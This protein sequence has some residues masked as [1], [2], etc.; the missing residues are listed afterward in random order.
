ME[1]HSCRMK[2][3]VNT[4][5]AWRAS[6]SGE[7]DPADGS[8]GAG[9]LL[10]PES[11]GIAPLTPNLSL[12]PSSRNAPRGHPFLVVVAIDLGT[13]ASGYAYS[14]VQEP[15]TI[16][17]MR[18][19][20]GGDPG[21]ANQKIP[22]C[23][24]LTPGRSFHS[25]GYTARDFYHDLDPEEAPH[26]FYFDKFKMKIHSFNV[27]FAL[28]DLTLETELEAVNGKSMRALHVFAH[29][30]R[31]FQNQ[32]LKEL[33]E[34]FC[35]DLEEE[36][37]RWVI[38]VPAIW[39]QP[40]KQFMREAAYLAGLAS[41]DHAEQLLIALEPEAA[42]IYCRKLRLH[43]L[44]VLGSTETPTSQASDPRINSSFR[45]A[46]EQ[47]RRSRQSRTFLMENGVGDLWAEMES[48]DRYIV[49]D[50]G[51]GTVDLTV[52]EIEQPEGTLKELY[53][54]SGGPYGAV[55]VD[56]AFEELL[57]QIFGHDFIRCFKVKRP[58]AWV[59]LMIAFEARK[60][61]VS[62]KRTNPLNISLPFSFIDFYRK[63][64]GK[65]VEAAL[66]K[67][68]NN[69][70][71]W[72]SQGM[73]R[74]LP[75][76]VDELFQPTI[77][78]VVQHIDALLHRPEVAGVRFLFL[79]GGFAESP[80]LQRAVQQ[81]VGG[82][83]RLVLPHGLGLSTLR[84]AVLFGLEPGVVRL[85]RSPLT[86]GLAVLR[87][88]EDGRH[89]ADKLLEQDGA[90]WCADV[91]DRLVQAQQPL[92]P[93][94]VV[95]RRYTPARPGQRSARIS[96]YCTPRPD[97]H[98]ISEPGVRRCGSLSLE[99]GP[100]PGDGGGPGVG[101]GDG[102]ELNPGLGVGRHREIRASLQ[103]G[104]TEIRVS[105]LDTLTGTEVRAAL[106]WLS[107]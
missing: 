25:L 56:L 48:G 75:E 16:H 60:R 91:F 3:A 43:Q 37:V 94:E 102:P 64:K 17:I 1:R 58:A 40:A 104:D 99:L 19:W 47:L 11:C 88:F 55:G 77:R 28:Q 21:V 105:A 32:A 51:G 79:V 97:V 85:R 5:T 6:D 14:L 76:A 7:E 59:D 107:D 57:C 44:T 71:K 92:A 8:P 78:Q 106:D 90:R 89:P 54:A 67:S 10:H 93:G 30:L 15:E 87:R 73:L 12:R 50:C 4:P 61:T 72:G 65:S 80:V 81:A 27:Q 42:S 82:G 49:A 39:K 70:V 46:R 26:W 95:Q 45:Q 84:G 63:Q 24:L 74:I 62:P 31:F 38:T 41:P 68:S 29:T 101:G 103:F 13:T 22:T 53:K 9:S 98:F 36:D 33:R 100:G 52:H 2:S 18:R 23:L 20:E 83:C 69:L 96:L 35:S 86:Y 66:K 34:Q